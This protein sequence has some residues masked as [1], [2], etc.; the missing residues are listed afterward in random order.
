MYIPVCIVH[1]YIVSS[2]FYS[3]RV[4]ASC[5]CFSCSGF[6]L[7]SFSFAFLFSHPTYFLLVKTTS[8]FGSAFSHR[9]LLVQHCL[10]KDNVFPLFTGGMDKDLFLFACEYKAPVATLFV[11][12]AAVFDFAA[13]MSCHTMFAFQLRPG[14]SP[15]TRDA[16]HIRLLYTA[17]VL[18]FVPAA[19]LCLV[20]LVG[21][22]VG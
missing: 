10:L 17:S 18:L 9:V 3:N 19:C 22:L 1:V 16:N 7:S 11:S 20:V 13:V 14:Q 12:P 21:W 8:R 6:H 15:A 2:P 5:S 4:L